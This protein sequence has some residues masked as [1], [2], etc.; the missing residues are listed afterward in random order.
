[1]AF[2]LKSKAQ[3]LVKTGESAAKRVGWSDNNYFHKPALFSTRY[4]FRFGEFREIN[5]GP[6]GSFGLGQIPPG[7]YRV[8]AFDN[9]QSDLAYNDTEAM[10]KFESKGE[11]VHL[12]AG[13]KE[14]LKL[15]LI[16]GGDVQ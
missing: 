16:T 14:H 10:R 4:A 8:L 6:D 7:T 3:P 5:A 15:K 11:V 13:Q 2:V 12:E 9:R 1:M